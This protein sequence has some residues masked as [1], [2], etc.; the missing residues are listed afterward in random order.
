MSNSKKTTENEIPAMPLTLAALPAT[1]PSQLG[2]KPVT[3]PG[4]LTQGRDFSEAL[5][6]TQ[7]LATAGT[8]EAAQARMA[9]LDGSALPAGIRIDTAQRLVTQGRDLPNLFAGANPSG[10]A[11]EVVAISDLRE[12]HSGRNPGIVN[13]PNHVASNVEDIRI[14]PHHASCKDLVFRFRTKDG[15]LITKYNGQVKTGSGQYIADSLWEMAKTPGYGKVG[16]VDGRFVNPDGTPRVASD[17]F[18][19]GQAEKLKQAKVRLRG[20]QDLDDRAQ[21]L[22]SNAQKHPLDGQDPVAREQVRQLRNDIAAAYH[23]KGVAVRMA[24]GAAIAAATAALVTLVVQWAT[25][26]KVEVASVGTAAGTAAL[27]GGGAAL[28]DAGLYQAANHLGMAPEAARSFAQT[29][30]ATGFC[31]LAIGVDVWS[32]I[33]MAKD[34]QITTAEAVAGSVAKAALD[35][36]PFVLAPLGLVGVPILIGAQLGGR[37]LLA[38][39]REKDRAI[40]AAIEEDFLQAGM[41]QARLDQMDQ[42]IQEIHQECNQTDELFHLV[43]QPQGCMNH[44]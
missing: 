15:M 7:P 40:S 39:Y 6:Q 35:V 2:V 18:T 30:V 12:L 4:V 24:S 16:I 8:R 22:L 19:S 14:S 13:P 26:G 28:A 33:K 25:D 20:I 32:E 27:Y 31:L 44:R 42:G 43:M 23:S 11:A 21:Q 10:K 9:V 38:K 36:L 17:A 41:M 29:G 3:D 1:G 5:R 37:W 34:G